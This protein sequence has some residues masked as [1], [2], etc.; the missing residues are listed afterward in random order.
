[1]ARTILRNQYFLISLPLIF[2]KP[3]T[4]DLAL[5]KLSTYF[6]MSVIR[7]LEPLPAIL[8]YLVCDVDTGVLIALV[9]YIMTQRIESS[10]S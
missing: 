8:L 10:C 4:S 2:T 7:D 5:G 1:M 6:F 9:D 3:S